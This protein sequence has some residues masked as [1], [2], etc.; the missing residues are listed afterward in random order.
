MMRRIFDVYSPEEMLSFNEGTYPIKGRVKFRV[1][2]PK[3]HT[4]LD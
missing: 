2:N 4:N 3:S 1:Y